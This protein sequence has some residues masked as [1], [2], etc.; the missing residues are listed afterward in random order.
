MLKRTVICILIILSTLSV[1]CRAYH[2][3]NNNQIYNEQELD[4]KPA[5][6]GGVNAM[7]E[8]VK[9]YLE[10]PE[11][12]GYNGYVILSAVISKK[13]NIIDAKVKRSLCVFC[14]LS[15][16]NVLKKM[17]KWIPGFKDRK[18]VNASIQIPIRLELLA[19]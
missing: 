18:P 2:G 16:L 8:F 14:D 1:S 4:S 5:Y 19:D 17:P 9:K 13:G 12:Y 6:P 3:I 11:D 10:W 15:A 7:K